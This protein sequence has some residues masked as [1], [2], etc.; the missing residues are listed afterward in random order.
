MNTQLLL[1]SAFLGLALFSAAAG[2]VIV[3]SSRKT[4]GS[5]ARLASITAEEVIHEQGIT[6]VV[7][8]DMRM[9]QMPLLNAI[10]ERIPGMRRLEHLL[11]Q[12]D[13]SIGFGA[14]LGIMIGLAGAGAV[15][16]AKI[17]HMP[18]MALPGAAAGY[19]PVMYAVRRK[20][21]RIAQFEKQ[22]PDSLDILNGALRAGLAFSAAIQVVAEESPA[23]VSSEFTIVFEENRLGLDLKDALMNLAR[24]IDSAELRMFVTAVILQRETG[25]NLVEILENAA[26][27]I[28]E[29]FR[30]LGE[31][32]AM[33]AQQRFSGL[34]LTLLPVGLAAFFMVAAPDYMRTL[35]TDP[36]GKYLIVGALSLQ[37][38]GYLV[39]RKIVAIKV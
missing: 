26:H 23:P 8:R 15:L 38:I 39:I 28:R 25:G 27:I 11:E 16:A 19:L 37:L 3:S 4:R 10:L 22:F 29:R 6:P 17:S 21:K 7:L 36:W 12:G 31:V 14:F 9:S 18:L 24:R 35:V 34:V 13:I 5:R 1:V 2:L 33:T 20:G 30:I 32:R